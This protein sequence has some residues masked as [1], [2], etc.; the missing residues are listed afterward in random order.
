[1]E[2]AHILKKNYDI[3]KMPQWKNAYNIIGTKKG[4][5]KSSLVKV[6]SSPLRSQTVS[7]YNLFQFNKHVKCM[8]TLT[9]KT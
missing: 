3:S 4:I 9:L 5:T 1:M 7:K 2:E 6:K 8:L